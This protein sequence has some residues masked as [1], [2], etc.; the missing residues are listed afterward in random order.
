MDARLPYVAQPYIEISS[1]VRK[2]PESQTGVVA[3]RRYMPPN[4]RQVVDVERDKSEKVKG[5]G[6]NDDTIS[7]SLEKVRNVFN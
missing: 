6:G 4:D 3:R 1:S 5:V 7:I 2:Q